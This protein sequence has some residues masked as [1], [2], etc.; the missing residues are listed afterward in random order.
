MPIT[1]SLFAAQTASC[2]GVT[3][4]VQNVSIE[5][6]TPLEDA[7]RLGRLKSAARVQKEASTSKGT[8]K[9]YLTSTGT[10]VGSALN[11]LVSGWSAGTT[12]SL[13]IDGVELMKGICT[14]I[15]VDAAVG[16][17]GFLTV[18]LEGIG[19][20]AMPA[21]AGSVD[22]NLAK[23]TPVTSDSITIA[24]NTVNSAKFS[25]DLPTDRLSKLGA[26]IT[27]LSA[28]TDNSDSHLFVGKPPYKATI[29]IDGPD[30][31]AGLATMTIGTLGITI[32][33]AAETAKSYSN[34]AG[35]TA[36]QYSFSFE[37]TDCTFS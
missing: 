16:D 28:M 13:S 14:N 31:S 32:A 34:S 4:P 3:L 5:S 36:G 19:T 1:R 21:S 27:G 17:F 25:I 22:D 11:T 2:G 8:V 9:F 33:D 10:S 29:T 23:F 18:S 7:M 30:L 24:G 26:T 37:G 12:S 6:T 15:S 20:S 35:D